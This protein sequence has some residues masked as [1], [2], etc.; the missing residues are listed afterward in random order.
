MKDKEEV[1]LRRDELARKINDLLGEEAIRRL[2]EGLTDVELFSL[3]TLCELGKVNF[4]CD[5][6]MGITLDT[7]SGGWTTQCFEMT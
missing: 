7:P 2:Y 4:H 5:G 1:S 6:Y 3:Q